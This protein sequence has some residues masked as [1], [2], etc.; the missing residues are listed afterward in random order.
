MKSLV[1]RKGSTGQ[2][3]ATA[4]RRCRIS[5][6][7]PALVS[8]RRLQRM[9]RS[10]ELYAPNYL[11]CARSE[12]HSRG[13]GSITARAYFFQNPDKGFGE[14]SLRNGLVTHL[15]VAR[16]RI[17]DARM[18]YTAC[19]CRGC[20]AGC[21]RWL[22]RTRRALKRPPPQ[23]R[24]TGLCAGRARHF[25]SRVVRTGR[26][27]RPSP[28]NRGFSLTLP[29]AFPPLYDDTGHPARRGARCR[30][31]AGV[32]RAWRGWRRG[33]ARGRP[34]SPCGCARPPG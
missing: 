1:H 8:R 28:A 12:P 5:S 14:R 4:R 23:G 29:F 20:R 2:I 18:R 19:G 15:S 11:P 17:P 25:R 31:T 32:S 24:C 33:R 16:V 27:G 21:H 7:A 26:S 10:S 3:T 22:S 13:L 9:T 34:G 6:G 30:R